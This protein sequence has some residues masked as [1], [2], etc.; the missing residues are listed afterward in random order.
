[1]DFVSNWDKTTSSIYMRWSK[2]IVKFIYIIYQKTIY[3][4]SLPF[5]LSQPLPTPFFFPT[6]LLTRF[7]IVLGGLVDHR[8]PPLWSSQWFFPK[9]WL[10]VFRVKNERRISL[11]DLL[12]VNFKSWEGM[13][14][15]LEWWTD[16]QEIVQFLMI[17]EEIKLNITRVIQGLLSLDFF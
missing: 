17:K 12:G 5:L 9:R 3:Y 1:M 16:R 7:P 15:F 10:W 2:L 11:A 8:A 4:L 13:E 6:C 14:F